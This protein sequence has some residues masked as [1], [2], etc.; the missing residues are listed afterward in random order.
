MVMAGSMH[1]LYNRVFVL[2]LVICVAVIIGINR[3][4]GQ[5]IHQDLQETVH[6]EVLEIL[7]EEQ[8]EIIGT[9]ARATVQQVRARITSGAKENSIIS[10]E[11]D[12]T[13]VAAG[14]RIIINR[15]ESID[16][17][18]YYVYK[19]AY[20]IPVLALSAFVFV[21]VLVLITGKKGIRALLSLCFSLA[22][23][24]YVLIPLLLAG[25]PAALTSTAIAALILAVTIFATHGRGAEAYIA[26]L[27]TALAVVATVILSYTSVTLAK[28]TGFSSEA[29]IYLNFSTQGALDFSGLL[30]GSIVIGVLGVLDDVAITQA[31]VTTELVRA[32]RALHG[33][34]LYRRALRV[35]QD[36]IGSLVNT[37]A[38]AYTGVSLPLLLLFA[39][40]ET[41][42]IDV[43]NQEVV[44]VEIVRTLIGSLG[45]IL[46][47][48]LT[49]AIAVWWVT[50]Y[51]VSADQH[52]HMHTHTHTHVS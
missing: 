11:N 52:V 5:T 42:V 18:E 17:A 49:T 40:A 37:L 35:G 13:R 9:D 31:S 50:R 46:T 25:Y 3:T 28:L 16:G 12:V 2:I 48:P 15:L 22:V 24:V 41:A 19:D 1:I 38:L 32:N 30:L 4:N 6:A 51:G 27:G 29:A 39:R 43:L 14:D 33:L 47:V 7:G 21:A 10:F 44:A 34:D 8:R 26:F 23:I 45:L 20:R 36:H